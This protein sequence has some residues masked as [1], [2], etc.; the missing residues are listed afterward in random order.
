MLGRGRRRDGA[1]PSTANCKGNEMSEFE[2]YTAPPPP[3]STGAPSAEERQW[4]L[5]G[6]ACGL[7]VLINANGIEGL[8][9]P[10]R[11]ANLAML[12]LIDEWKPSSVTGTPFFFAVL[13]A[14]IALLLWKRPSVQPVRAALLVFLLG[15]PLLQMRHL[16]LL[17]IIAAMLLPTAFSRRD[18]ATGQTEVRWV[19]ALAAGIVDLRAVL[20]IELPYNNANP[21]KLIAQVPPEL[22]AQPVINGYGMGGPLILSGIRPYID[23]RG[24]MYGDE[25]VVGYKK[26]IDGEPVALAK[27]ERRWGIRWAILPLQ[28]R[29]LI[30]L[31]DRSPGWRRIY[32][33]EVGVIYVR[34]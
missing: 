6:V 3:P 13:A 23:G 5:F 10:L 27:S 33:D 12:P 7:A 17:A 24:D 22:R 34:S 32:G 18:T 28:Y 1:I 30:A 25:L 21:W 14:T 9:H 26:I 15:M 4:G 29:E 19:Q 2:T 11:I 8:L 16:A 31:L 20:P